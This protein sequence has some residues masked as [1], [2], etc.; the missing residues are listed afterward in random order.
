MNLIPAIRSRRTVR[1]F[2]DE[3][4]SAEAVQLLLEAG[5]RAP[6]SRGGHTTQ[7]I[8]LE[9]R[10]MLDRLSYMRPDGTDPLKQVPLGIVVL[11]S[12]MECEKWI[13]DGSLAAGYIQ[14]QAEELGLGSCWVDV[15][16]QYTESGQ[17]SAE[18]VRQALDIPYQLEVLC[19]LAVGHRAEEPR[20]RQSEELRWEQ[21]HLGGYTL[22]EEESEDG[23]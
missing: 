9:D 6:S 15:Y 21:I 16:G 19:V 2:T 4:L 17:E 8:L 23:N 3:P 7:F 5:L 1:H 13:A 14:L 20:E 11:G 22:P 18:Y 10:E 12:P